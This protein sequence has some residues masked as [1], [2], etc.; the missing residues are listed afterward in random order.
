MLLSHFFDCR[1]QDLLHI[2][3]CFVPTQCAKLDN[4]RVLVELR[5][6]VANRK[7]RIFRV[8]LTFFNEYIANFQEALML[9]QLILLTDAD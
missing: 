4:I 5:D 2:T 8:L 1:I 6:T 3:G 7:T 9:G